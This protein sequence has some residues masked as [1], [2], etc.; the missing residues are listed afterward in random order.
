[1]DRSHKDKDA[2]REN[3][4][5]PL[6]ESLAELYTIANPRDRLPPLNKR[7]TTDESELNDTL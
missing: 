3:V 5:A 6:Y 7:R 1:M 2:M 4:Q